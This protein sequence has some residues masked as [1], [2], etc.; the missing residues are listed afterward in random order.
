[1]PTKPQ[2]HCSWLTPSCCPCQAMSLWSL[3]AGKG[4]CAGW[5]HHKLGNSAVNSS[6]CTSRWPTSPPVSRVHPHVNKCC[7]AALLVCHQQLCMAGAVEPC[8]Q[9]PQQHAARKAAGV[10]GVCKGQAGQP[11]DEVP[12]GGRRHKGEDSEMIRKT[13]VKE[14]VCSCTAREPSK[15]TTGKVLKRWEPSRARAVLAHQWHALLSRTVALWWWCPGHRGEQAP[16][17]ESHTSH[18]QPLTKSLT[19]PGPWTTQPLGS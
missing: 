4:G 7:Q 12:A 2:Q 5:H 14:V 13:G 18:A 1:M 15:K 16:K 8:G 10:A 17:P 3:R 19:L 11:E 9:Q 6:S